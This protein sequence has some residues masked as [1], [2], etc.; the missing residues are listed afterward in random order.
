MLGPI[1]F[2]TVLGITA[3]ASIVAERVGRPGLALGCFIAEIVIAFGGVLVV[4]GA[5]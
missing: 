2:L 1:L 5:N 4:I 3:M